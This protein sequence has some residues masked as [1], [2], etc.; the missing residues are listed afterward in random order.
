MLFVQRFS[1]QR[2]STMHNFRS[3]IRNLHAPAP[4]HCSRKKIQSRD[5][6]SLRKNG[7]VFDSFRALLAGFAV[8]DDFI[9]AS[10]CK[11]LCEALD[12]AEK[13]SLL[14]PN[15]T[16]ATYSSDG[17]DGSRKEKLY[18]EK[19]GI[20]EAELGLDSTKR[21]LPYCL[22]AL[23]EDRKLLDELSAFFPEWQL[24][25]QALKGQINLGSGGSF[26]LHSDSDR[27]T[28]HRHSTILHI[29]LQRKYPYL[30][31]FLEFYI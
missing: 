27:K 3:T 17:K 29:I 7:T 11:K 5:I 19:H 13:L 4:L 15:A 16:H 25:S 22:R 31:K 2:F 6:D 28:D 21:M 30:R 20:I 1:T 24:D 10:D 12:E 9:P 14:L 18:V 8:I 26:P 23:S